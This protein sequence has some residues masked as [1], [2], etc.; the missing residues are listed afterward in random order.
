MSDEDA[1][2]E[3]G[4]NEPDVDPDLDIDEVSLQISSTHM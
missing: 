4:A 2:V 1:D 3:Y